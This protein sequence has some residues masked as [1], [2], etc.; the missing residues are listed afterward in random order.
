MFQ[1]ELE[2]FDESEYESSEVEL[3]DLHEV[4][5]SRSPQFLQ[6][7]RLHPR[8]PRV[9]DITFTR[10]PRRGAI[11][12]QGGRLS[13]SSSVSLLSTPPML[14]SDEFSSAPDSGI[15]DLNSAVQA[16]SV[17]Y[18]EDDEDIESISA[19]D[20]QREG[21]DEGGIAEIEKSV[22]EGVDDVES[23]S[24]EGAS[25]EEEDVDA[26]YLSSAHPALG[27][28]EASQ[29][30]E[31]EGMD[32]GPQDSNGL[33]MYSQTDSEPSDTASDNSPSQDL[34]LNDF[35]EG[36]FATNSDP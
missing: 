31:Q 7:V 24:E 22:D 28:G 17:D 9:A 33:T 30:E 32:A 25:T 20:P 27:V 6:T 5:S 19:A 8:S 34:E 26:W 36:D 29:D 21:D 13:S 2:D 35:S 18:T 15:L 11:S 4:L 1:P 12:N 16:I 14:P 23:A 3:P 10:I